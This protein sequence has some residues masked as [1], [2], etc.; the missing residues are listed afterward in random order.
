MAANS[1]MIPLRDLIVRDLFENFRRHHTKPVKD[2]TPQDS[3]IGQYYEGLA[4]RGFRVQVRK[5]WLYGSPCDNRDLIQY[6][7]NSLWREYRF[8]PV[9]DEQWELIEPLACV[10]VDRGDLKSLDAMEKRQR[11]KVIREKMRRLGNANSGKLN[12]GGVTNEQLCALIDAM[13]D[14]NSDESSVRVIETLH[15]CKLNRAIAVEQSDNPNL[16]KLGNGEVERERIRKDIERA[17]G[18]D[19]ELLKL[20][21]LTGGE[22]ENRI[23]DAIHA[24]IDKKACQW[25]GNCGCNLSA[26]DEN[27]DEWYSAP[28]RVV[29]IPV[30]LVELWRE[31]FDGQRVQIVEKP[32][33]ESADAFRLYAALSS[34]G[35]RNVPG[36]VEVPLARRLTDNETLYLIGRDLI[37]AEWMEECLNRV[38]KGAGKG[39]ELTALVRR[40]ADEGRRRLF[41]ERIEE[42]NE[43]LCSQ[44]VLLRGQ[45]LNVRERKCVLA[46][47]VGRTKRIPTRQNSKDLWVPSILDLQLQQYKED[48]LQ[49]LTDQLPLLDKMISAFKRTNETV[50]R[51]SV[52]D[53]QSKKCDFVRMRIKLHDSL[54]DVRVLP[55]TPE[56]E[57]DMAGVI[58]QYAKV[59]RRVFFPY[60]AVNHDRPENCPER[61]QEFFEG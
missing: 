26:S 35:S 10:C 24:E 9:I 39:E 11:N 20:D 45:M 38:E 19:N 16:P 31:R 13:L 3:V 60:Q 48:K 29:D 51:Q 7:A 42:V 36:T 17:S 23:D 12:L 49:Q 30:G 57:H 53:F 2:G 1:E 21:T 33:D 43:Y 61:Y 55:D 46:V 14:C 58:R 4:E 40:S 27:E 59:P 25:F 6:L 52:S 50:F 34:S 8:T 15:V 5:K 18:K 28:I 47:I 37:D 22:F 41:E 54:A 44:I 32:S 56:N